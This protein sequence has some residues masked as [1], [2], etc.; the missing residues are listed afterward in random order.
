MRTF[1]AIEKFEDGLR[2]NLVG[3]AFAEGRMGS[4]EHLKEGADDGVKPIF[5][6]VGRAINSLCDTD[7]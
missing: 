4:E 3:Q 2:G 5:D 6:G 1:A 7:W